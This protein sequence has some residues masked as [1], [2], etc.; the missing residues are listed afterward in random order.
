MIAIDSIITNK[1]IWK[2]IDNMLQLILEIKRRE[3]YREL[4]QDK[5]ENTGSNTKDKA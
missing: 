4:K 5:H 2:E 1:T 3:F